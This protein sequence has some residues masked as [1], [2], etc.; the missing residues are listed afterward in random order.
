MIKM[1]ERLPA[2]WGTR[3][4]RERTVEFS[5]AGRT[6]QGLHGDSIASAVAANGSYLLSRSFKY[7]RPRGPLSFA[8]QDANTLVHIPG[9][10]N[11]LAD[12]EPATDGMQVQPIN[13]L[14]SLQR[15][16]GSALG[17]FSRFLPV[18]FYYKAFFK[19]RGIWEYW[20]PIIRRMAGLSPL[21]LSY[22]EPRTDKFYGFFDVVV[23]GAGRAGME[24]AL[25]AARQGERILLLDQ[26]PEPGGS[27]NYSRRDA[28][29][30][31]ARELAQQLAAQVAAEPGIELLTGATCTG[32]FADHWLSVIYRSQLHK[33]RTG[34]T[35]LAVGTLQQPVIFRNNDLPGIML[36]SAAQR[37]LHYYGIAPGQ[38]AVIVTADNEGYACALDL[39]DAGV[40]VEALV[41]LREQPATGE[42]ATEVQR[43]QVRVLQGQTVWEAQADSSHRIAQVEVRPL[44]GE[45]VSQHAGE[46]L[47]CDVLC[48]S[49]GQMP[50]WQLACMAGAKLEYQ[51]DQARFQ[52]T[53]LPDGMQVSGSAANASGKD[54]GA[55][56]PWP[57]FPHP[58]G[59]EFVDFDEDLQIDDI[60]N[61]TREGY[62]HIQLVKRFSTV[63]M[64][65]SQGRHSALATARLVARAT[66]RSIAET[67]ITTARPPASAETLGQ[68]AGRRFYPTRYSNM[69]Q[70]H[71]AAGATLLQAGAWYRPAYYGP[72]RETAI[73]A[74]ITNVRNNAGVIDVSTLGGLEIRG[75]DAAEFLNRI[76]TFAFVKQEVGRCRYAL[77]TNE[78]GVVI[79]DGV[80]CRLAVDH[81]YVTATTT[82]VDRVFQT[83]LK[84]NTQWQL[85]VDIANVT[86]A[87]AAVNIAG[88]RSREILAQ[89][90]PELPLEQEAFP[91]MG[92]RV[93]QVAGI[94]A[95]IL[96][97]GF[98]GEL[99]Y[100]IH[101][102]QHCGEALWDAITDLGVSPFGVEA[103][104]VLRLEKGHV[105]IGQDTDAMSTPQQIQM[106]WA[107][108]RKKAFF[109]G[110][111]SLRELEAQGVGRCLVG[112]VLPG[113]ESQLPAES[114]LVVNG[115]Q[116]VGRVTSCAYS[117]TLQRGIGLAYVSPAL[118]E[119]GTSITIKLTGGERLNA[120]VVNT[121]F[122]DADNSRQDI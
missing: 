99:G 8:G 120:Q 16:W 38:R 58:R 41:D 59:K 26:N 102:P 12:L 80:A 42:V 13:V 37:L 51:E 22:R 4:D 114:H 19:P 119:P 33:I 55:T 110:D 56:H 115:E 49:G 35:V 109:V 76:Y 108:S 71:I 122:Y 94:P 24:A 88:P 18:G 46:T 45:S 17:L 86:T 66:H 112:F 96:R 60:V 61:A 100:E 14:G 93:A 28:A 15:D 75:A 92:A 29:G 27:L 10:P 113:G 40:Q 65:P 63:G 36:C 101:V 64:G 116:M 30:L 87:W 34:R 103:Q 5:F 7:H 54:W 78:A 72:E 82:G 117:P 106:G 84:W 21:D 111:R 98:V 2:P 74:E 85:D 121:P 32:W 43:R 67:G 11:S 9:K 73:N 91:Y 81:Y 25:D 3:I 79:D 31:A 6:Y 20:A 97:V 68:L 53:Q 90:C 57:I 50:A 105:I 47:R 83:M 52:L 1:S 118:A 48:M 77:M 95:R 70:R 23:I 44:V 39:L 107:V 104:R 62:D 69:H 89:L